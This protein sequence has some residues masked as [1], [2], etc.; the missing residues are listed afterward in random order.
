MLPLIIQVWV[1]DL[2]CTVTGCGACHR[3]ALCADPLASPG[4]RCT[5]SGTRGC[6]SMIIPRHPNLA[7]DVVVAG[8]KLHACAGGL[9]ADGLPVKLLPRR[10]VGGV[11][12]AAL[13]VELG[14]A[15]LQLSVGDQDVGG[16]LIEVDTD[17]VTG[18]K[19]SKPAVGSG[20]RR[21]IQDRWR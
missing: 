16:A 14:V 3:A 12:E 13:G 5:A 20:F 6:S 2:R 21:R 10:L 11:G 15:A 1:P 9:L 17:P 7:R 8:C 4:K 18:G 19:H